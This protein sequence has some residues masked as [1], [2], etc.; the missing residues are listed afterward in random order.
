VILRRASEHPVNAPRSH[1]RN[2]RREGGDYEALSLNL[3]V[4]SSPEEPV[5]TKDGRNA[6]EPYRVRAAGVWYWVD[7]SA[8]NIE[9][10]DTVV[11]YPVKGDAHIVALQ[12]PWPG[13]GPIGF[14]PPDGERFDLAARDIA[15]LHLAVED[16]EQN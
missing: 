9:P 3:Q 12:T 8:R 5:V 1:G 15:T 11:L 6:T 16:E 4:Q 10:G 14:S 7:P 2:E 13:D